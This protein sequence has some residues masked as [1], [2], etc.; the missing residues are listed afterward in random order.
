[1]K[2]RLRTLGVLAIGCA[3]AL[4]APAGASAK[5]VLTQLH[6]EAGGRALSPNTVYVNDTARLRA[7]R[8]AGCGGSGKSITLEGPT[9]LGVLDYAQETNG[10]VRPLLVSD[11]FSFGL[12]VC[13]IGDFRDAGASAYWLYKVNHASPEVGAD[14]RRVRSNDQVLW[15]YVDN[16]TNQNTGDELVLEA[17]ARARPG[18][19]VDVRVL[20]FS[21]SGVGVAAPGAEVRFG[22]NAV[23][24]GPDG[25]ATFTAGSEGTL[26]LRAVRGADVPAA[27]VGVCV[28]AT[29]SRCPSI[30]GARTVGTNRSE[31]IVSG[32]GGD[33]IFA[34]GGN[35]IVD[36]RGG[37]PDTVD[38]GRGRDTA[39][40]SGNDRAARDCE[41]V[42]HRSGTASRSRSARIGS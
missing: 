25:T 27:P 4:A 33:A 11:K 29:L 12:F 34:R 39:I 38:C 6:V 2:L 42:L 16:R 17:P 15:Y 24:T 36:V 14:Q 3:I 1:M 5:P 22:Q 37:N 41:R 21:P 23:T 40:V 26:D 9:A 28:N 10:R 18:G 7:S 31:R 19:T 8:S 32:S 20:A 30:R 13:G 35:D